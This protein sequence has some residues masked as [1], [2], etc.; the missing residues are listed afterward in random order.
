MFGSGRL[1]QIGPLTVRMLFYLTGLAI[2]SGRMLFR[3]KLSGT[4]AMLVLVFIALLSVGSIVGL[5]MGFPRDAVAEDVKP[6]LFFFS[7]LF[8]DH[9]IDDV[10]RVRNVSA[11]IRAGAVVLAS[12]YLGV[13]ALVR[14]GILPFG[15]LYAIASGSG[16]FFF[17]GDTGTFVYKGFLYLGVGFFFFAFRPKLRDKFLASALLIALMLTFTRGLLLAAVVVA[18]F[19]FIIR[20]RNPVRAWVVVGALASLTLVVWPLYQSRLVSRSASDTVRMADVTAVAAHTTV[21]SL[22]LGRGFG[23]P[24]SE[25]GRIEESYLEVLYKQGL[26][27]LIFWAV[28]LAMLVRSF[29]EAARAGNGDEALPFLLSG[30]F[31]FAESATN[32]FLTNP[33]GMSMVLIALVAERVL[34]RTPRTPQSSRVLS[35]IPQ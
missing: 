31:V 11:V 33:I 24:I 21:P 12:A 18:C 27:G 19:A 13:L 32:P 35:S 9:A 6:L 14:L 30:V 16:E 20:Q 34:A 22:I 29:Q 26:P 1:L 17:R 8:F 25:R 5:V 28:V 7:L 3:A 10:A 4:D 15:L 2:V 23:A